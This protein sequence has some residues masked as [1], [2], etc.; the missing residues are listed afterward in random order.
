M[1]RL[2]S[3]L[4]ML[5]SLP[6]SAQS[7]SC[8]QRERV[9]AKLTGLGETQAGMGLSTKGQVFEIW[10]SNRTGTWTIV[11]SHSTGLSC[12]MSYGQSWTG[13]GAETASM[14]GEPT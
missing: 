8:D 12:I 13:Q 6:A 3:V 2:T 7:V 5:L 1:L 9:V 4:V 10:S 11:L 14:P